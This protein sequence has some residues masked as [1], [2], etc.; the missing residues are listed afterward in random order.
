MPRRIRRTKR[1]FNSAAE[2]D[3]WSM[4]FCYGRDYFN[5]LEDIGFV[6][7]AQIIAALPEA[8]RRLGVDFMARWAQMGSVE[9]GN[10]KF[11]WA[12]DQFGK[13]PC[14]QGDDSQSRARATSQRK[15]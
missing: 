14:L 15:S 11:P 13:K 7:V 2:I 12:H 4:M 8:W 5:D 3:A 10:R 1:R 6:T 9:K